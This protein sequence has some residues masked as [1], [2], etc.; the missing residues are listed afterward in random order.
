MKRTKK[1]YWIFTILFA[2]FMIM[3][4]IPDVMLHPVAVQGMHGDLGYPQYFIPFIGV[5]KLLGVLAILIPGKYPSIKEW[6][7]AGLFYDLLGATY[8]V[9]AA[10]Q[11]IQACAFMSLP[12]SLA[13]LSFRYYRKTLRV[14]SITGSQDQKPAYE[15]ANV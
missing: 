13:I 2:A 1:L 9:I 6:A 11:P 15:L 10:G 5:A 14:V 12:L 4:A 8:S 7:Y 3:S